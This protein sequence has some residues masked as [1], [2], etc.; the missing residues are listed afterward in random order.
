MRQVV[1]N[2]VTT[3]TSSFWSA[4]LWDCIGCEWRGGG[5]HGTI[6]VGGARSTN[7]RLD[8]VYSL[9]G[10]VIWPGVLR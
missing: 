7:I 1:I 3:F 8:T 2:D 10:S 4:T 6:A 5:I 9:N